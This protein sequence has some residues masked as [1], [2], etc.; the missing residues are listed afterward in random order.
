MTKIMSFPNYICIYK[1]RYFLICMQ[2]VLQNQNS[3]WVGLDVAWLLGVL[4]FLSG[5]VYILV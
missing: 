5:T 4:W 1:Y 2:V 3:H